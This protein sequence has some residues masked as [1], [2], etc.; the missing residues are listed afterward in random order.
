MSDIKVTKNDY[1]VEPLHQWDVNQQLQIYGLSLASVPEV[2]FSNQ[3]MDKA[4]VRQAKM[5]K[6]GVITVDVPNG[7]LQKY[8]TINVYLCT[9]DGGTF[10]T[11]YKIDVPVMERP[12]PADYSIEAD[13]DVYSFKALENQVT[14]VLNKFDEVDKRYNASVANYNAAATAYNNAEKSLEKIQQADE[15]VRTSYTRDEILDADTKAALGLPAGAVPKEAFN[16]LTKIAYGFYVGTGTYKQ[17]NANSLTFDFVPKV[18][19]FGAFGGIVAIKDTA[20]VTYY[21]TTNHQLYFVWSG[22]T[23]S[24]YSTESAG[25]QM[26]TEGTTYFY[27][28]LG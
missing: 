22:N 12:K 19:L 4:I 3:A 7:L 2:H 17:A 15:I 9:Y 1:T 18:I 21:T 6:A 8:Y 26:N 14:N 24:W 10:Q 5:D 16:T 27:V 20:T 23:V 13:Q 28:A 25:W 11:L